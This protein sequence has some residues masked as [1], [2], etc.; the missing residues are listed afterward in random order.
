MN[1]LNLQSVATKFLCGALYYQFAP[2]SWHQGALVAQ[3]SGYAMSALMTAALS[4][5]QD[6]SVVR[7]MEL[8]SPFVVI[9]FMTFFQDI[10]WK[11]YLLSTAIL[12]SIQVAIDIFLRALHQGSFS[13]LF[14]GS[15]NRT[16]PLWTHA[17][18]GSVL[19]NKLPPLCFDDRYILSKESDGRLHGKRDEASQFSLQEGSVF[20]LEGLVPCIEFQCDALTPLI[21]SL[22]ITQNAVH[23]SSKGSVNFPK[24][25]RETMQL[26]EKASSCCWCYPVLL[27]PERAETTIHEIRTNPEIPSFLVGLLL[28][29]GFAFFD[30][31]GQLLTVRAMTESETTSQTLITKN[32]MSGGLL[33]DRVR[34]EFESGVEKASGLGEWEIYPGGIACSTAH[35]VTMPHL[36]DHLTHYA[37]FP[38]NVLLQQSWK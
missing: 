16:E 28:H 33:P 9:G 4:R 7:K 15:G 22:A 14:P 21:N 6:E 26:P 31:S 5:H 23:T 27:D 38:A 2:Q 36:Q 13:S 24:E 18:D 17:A 11:V 10:S 35:Q 12:G 37:F 29:G 8:F 20:L 30:E 1:N 19:L 32:T 3:I 25:L 34:Q